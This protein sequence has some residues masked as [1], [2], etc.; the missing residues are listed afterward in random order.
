MLPSAAGRASSHH[1]WRGSLTRCMPSLTSS[2]AIASSVYTSLAD[3]ST[4]HR[5]QATYMCCKYPVRI[6]MPVFIHICFERERLVAI[7]AP[8]SAA[9]SSQRCTC[10]VGIK[11]RRVLNRTHLNASQQTGVGCVMVYVLPVCRSAHFL[12]T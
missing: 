3:N 7:R 11:Q 10:F 8:T 4:P 5:K 2:C 1:S 6:L 9:Q 12:C